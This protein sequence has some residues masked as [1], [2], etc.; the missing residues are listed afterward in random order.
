[1][2]TK[3]SEEL[4]IALVSGGM[5]SL[6]SAAMA[7]EKHE[8]MAFLHLN[9]GQKTEERE[10]KSFNNIAIYKLLS[11]DNRDGIISSINDDDYAGTRRQ[12]LNEKSTYIGTNWQ[13]S[14]L[15]NISE[16][17]IRDEIY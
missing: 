4:A 16:R 3:K 12:I 9:Y 11:K 13:Q 8:H 6:V 7:N 14:M 5:D 17:D 1:M 2:T 10:L 15:D